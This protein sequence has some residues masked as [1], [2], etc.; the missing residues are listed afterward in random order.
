MSSPI[1]ARL[2]IL[3]PEIGDYIDGL[4]GQTSELAA[5]LAANARDRGFPLIGETSGRWLE[6][7]TR[8]IG[9]KRV[10]EFGSGFGFSAYYFARAVGADGEVIGS[11]CDAHEFD[12]FDRLFKDEPLRDRITIH[13]GSAF[14]IFAATDG[15]FDVILL[16]IDKEDYVAA[17]DL[18][19][20]RVR[21][22]GLILADNV[23]WGG[24][25]AKPA[26]DGDAATAALRLFNERIFAD[27]RLLTG[28]LPCG[29]GLSVSLVKP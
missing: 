18:A 24:R 3:T 19:L 6:L 22:G 1:D 21:P 29:D 11:E 8:A 13:H 25:T 9:G 2:P 10:F 4:T 7:L 15:T 14:E 12:D 17:L 20:E 5:R 28:I 26:Q 27:D 23:L 16:D